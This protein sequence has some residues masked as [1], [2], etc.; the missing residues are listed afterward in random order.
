MPKVFGG[1][2]WS[3][4]WGWVVGVGVGRVGVDF[5][6]VGGPGHGDSLDCLGNNTD[7]FLT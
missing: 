3:R 7:L 6:S 5:W 1:S 2:E 4:V